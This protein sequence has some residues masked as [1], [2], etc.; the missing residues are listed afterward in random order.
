MHEATKEAIEWEKQMI[1]FVANQKKEPSKIRKEWLQ[2]TL[3][4]PLLKYEALAINKEIQK[5]GMV[6]IYEGNIA[7]E[8]ETKLIVDSQPKWRKAWLK[9][10]PQYL[11]HLVEAPKPIRDDLSFCPVSRVRTWR[12]HQ[13]IQRSHP[14]WLNFLNTRAEGRRENR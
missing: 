2:P 4:Y 13:I 14:T 3:P 12:E 11:L 7:N 10:H 1:Q 6:P 5:E 9:K 8:D